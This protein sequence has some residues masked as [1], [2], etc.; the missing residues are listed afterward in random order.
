[1]RYRARY[2]KFWMKIGL[3]LAAVWAIA[4]GAILLA[5][6]HRPTPQSVAAYFSEDLGPASD[7]ARKKRIEK[8][9]IMLNQLTFEERQQLRRDRTQDQFFKSLTPEEQG[10]FLDATL[11]TGFRQ[12][13]ENFNRMDPAKR[14]QFVDRALSQMKAREGNAPQ[15]PIDDANVQKIVNQ[16][17]RSFYND[18]SA[19][20]KLD[21][22]PLIEEMQKT[23]FGR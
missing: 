23:N 5:R 1:M 20:V 14:K 9:A 4:G 22:A 21:M 6:A 19:E 13:M 10:R 12:M 3:A 11:P 18:A 15:R 16:G 7:A 2:V 8:A 17:M